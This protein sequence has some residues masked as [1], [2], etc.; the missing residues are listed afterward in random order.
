MNLVGKIFV[1]LILVMSIVFMSFAIAVYATH[2]NWRDVVLG[3]PAKGQSGMKEELQKRTNE[4]EELKATRL[5]LETELANVRSSR[6]R[7]VAALETER[8]NA[9]KETARLNTEINRLNKDVADAVNAMGLTQDTLKKLREQLAVLQEQIDTARLERDEKF[10][11]VVKLTD[12]L[13]QATGELSRLDQ[14][15]KKLVQDNTALSLALQDA[16][17]QLDRTGPPRI[18]GIIL[19]S[20]PNG[21]VEISLGSDDGL[22]KNHQLDVYRLGPSLA[23]NKYLGKIEVVET[24]ADRAVARI[25]PNFRKGTI[26]KE[27]RVA[28]RLN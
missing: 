2:R 13:A 12:D 21:Y 14:T 25:L 11:E 6:D 8:D 27:D 3:N 1:V 28:T 9:I 16:N 23:E 10:K 7:A 26:Q 5:R 18:D 17:I 22:E 20:R 15:N 4:L 19:A 24:Q